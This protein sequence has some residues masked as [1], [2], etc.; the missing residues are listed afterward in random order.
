MF[1]GS[2][3]DYIF[4]LILLT[5]YSAVGLLAIWAALGRP[6]WFVRVGL[7]GAALV[8]GVLV[9]AH[10]LVVNLFL[11][12]VVVVVSLEI[13]RWLRSRKEKGT[14]ALQFSLLDLL[15]VTSLAAVTVAAGVSIPAK[16]WTDWSLP[17]LPAALTSNPALV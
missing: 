12:C 2:T 6:Y 13:V 16:V 3:C 10:E 1:V 11:E 5:T 8:P 15:L 17:V 9:E 14:A 7:L 4:L